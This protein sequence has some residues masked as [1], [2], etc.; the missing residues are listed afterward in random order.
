MKDDKMNQIAYCGLCCPKC[1]N[2]KVGQ[3]AE[4]L[5]KEIESAE[6]K[7]ATLGEE[8]PL[9]KKALDKLARLQCLKFCREGGGKSAT[10]K[11]KKCCDDH[12]ISGCWECSD[13]EKCQNLKPQFVSNIKKI[14]ELGIDKYIEDYQ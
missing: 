3:A 13:F 12:E 1:Y 14:Q 7:G 4:N 11:I 10:C 5:Q 6:E 9:L 2:M 8:Y